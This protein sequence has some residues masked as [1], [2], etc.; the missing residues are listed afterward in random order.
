MSTALSAAVRRLEPGPE[1]QQ[2]TRTGVCVCVCVSEPAAEASQ[3]FETDRTGSH[4]TA[5]N[6]VW[7]DFRL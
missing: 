3:V 7:K 2:R 4:Q 1:V 5:Q 6:D